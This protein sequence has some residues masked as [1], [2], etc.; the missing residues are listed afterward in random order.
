MDARADIYSLGCSLYYVLTGHP[1]FDEGTLPQRLMAHQKQQPPSI[2]DSRPDAP[3]DL[4][5]ICLK[6]MAKKP[7]NRYQSAQEVAEA[8]G[9]WLTDHGYSTGSGIGGTGSSGRL[10]AATARPVTMVKELESPSKARTL[11]K[12]VPLR[13]AGSGGGSR[14]RSA[15]PVTPVAHEDTIAAR[16]VHTV[17]G[18]D[19]A[20]TPSPIA[21]P[22]DSKSGGKR[23]LQVA[24]P[25]EAVALPAEPMAL[26]AEPEA[27][28]AELEA[29]PAEPEALPAEPEAL[30]AEPMAL[31]A[32][33][34]AKPPKRVAKPGGST[35][36]AAKVVAKPGG[37]AV[38]AAK[39]V[40]KPAAGVALPIE[41]NDSP[42]GFLAEEPPPFVGGA[43]QHVPTTPEQVAAYRA[44]HKE[45]P[46]W[47]WMAVA[48]GCVLIV[49]ML[50]A[51]VVI[52]AH[53]A[54]KPPSEPAPAVEKLKKIG[55]KTDD[56]PLAARDEPIYRE[57]ICRL[58]A[59]RISLRLPERNPFRSSETYLKPSL[60]S[61][62][63]TSSRNWGSRN[64]AIASIDT[65]IRAMSPL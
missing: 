40:A 10:T 47:L 46:I 21:S 9:Q 6:M 15:P 50:L 53:R 17:K 4:V 62:P 41:D 32:A 26:P 13:A 20:R 28:P 45:V 35:V 42:F 25:L 7:A 16:Q 18:S 39:V 59:G 23:G 58:S 54:K 2:Y 24:K 37:S 65:S 5:D 14:P 19:V 44:H 49:V 52:K 61:S 48:G 3:A 57:R 34:A 31:P 64:L 60:V 22:S 33:P 29:L 12:A 36:P 38:R 1:P 56:D 55:P 43:V 8:L 30:P 51:V 27:L 11:S 63:I